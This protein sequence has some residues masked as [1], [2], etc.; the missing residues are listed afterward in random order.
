MKQ[1]ARARLVSQPNI[2]SSL[3]CDRQ[4]P[5]PLRLCLWSWLLC[6]SGGLPSGRGEDPVYELTPRPVPQPLRLYA[7]DGDP[8]GPHSLL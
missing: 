8:G 1:K 6:H 5:L 2:C 7:E 4:L 3:T